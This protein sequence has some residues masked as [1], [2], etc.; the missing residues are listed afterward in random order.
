MIRILLEE[1]AVVDRVVDSEKGSALTIAMR[2]NYVCAE[3][4]LREYGAA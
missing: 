4:L 3:Q 2:N 1:G